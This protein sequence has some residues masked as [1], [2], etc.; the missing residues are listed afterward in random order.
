[1]GTWGTGLYDNDTTSDVRDIYMQYLREQ[2]SNME[3]YKKT[4]EGFQGLI[5]D[6]DEEPL[7]WYA[8][9]ETQ[10]RMGRLT[11]DVKDKALYWI[12]K[13]GGGALWEDSGVNRTE[14][15]ET[16]KKLKITLESPIRSEKKIKKP[17][18]ENRSF[19]NVGDVYA[20]KFHKEESRESGLYGK[21]I[22]IQKIGE[23]KG[24]EVLDIAPLL[25]RVHIYDKVFDA[26]PTLS[27]IDGIRLLPISDP[28]VNRRLNMSILIDY[29]KKKN[30]PMQYLYHMGN[31]A[32]TVNE[33]VEPEEDAFFWEYIEK[34]FFYYFEMWKNK[35]YEVLEGGIYLYTEKNTFN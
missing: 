33:T 5:G 29:I 2:L 11:P 14:W 20:Y 28:R 34:T 31:V 12:A 13:E 17:K 1:M 21:Y 10:W 22:L 3:A 25:M 8:L 18:M 23:G 32:V 4:V 26:L 19:W 15:G 35:E 30:V 27:D 6:E 9:A 7:F 16:L 24:D